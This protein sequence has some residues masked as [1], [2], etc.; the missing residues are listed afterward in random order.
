MTSLMGTLGNFLSDQ[1]FYHNLKQKRAFSL[2]GIEVDQNAAQIAPNALNKNQTLVSPISIEKKFQWQN[3][4][5][6]YCSLW[7]FGPYL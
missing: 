3:L 1:S 7:V 2:K 5:D 4:V 6:S